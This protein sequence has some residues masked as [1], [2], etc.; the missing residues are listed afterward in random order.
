MPSVNNLEILYK[1]WYGW[2][3]A[4]MLL[5]PIH[6]CTKSFS[7]T[8]LSPSRARLAHDTYLPLRWSQPG[9]SHP[10]KRHTWLSESKE[11]PAKLTLYAGYYI[12]L[13]YC[14]LKQSYNNDFFFF[15][16]F[17]SWSPNQA[18]SFNFRWIKKGS[19]GFRMWKES[20]QEEVG[21]SIHTRKRKKRRPGYILTWRERSFLCICPAKVVNG[22]I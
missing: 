2:A 8:K 12:I 11:R 21:E 17:F 3:A 14:F 4:R 6:H 9:G 19:R 22:M 10:C 1:S 13:Q 15:F 18:L 16:P 20:H 7:M 5:D